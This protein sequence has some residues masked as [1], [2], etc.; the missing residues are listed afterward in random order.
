MQCPKCDYEP[1]LAEI[2]RSP[3]DCVS[4]GIN[5]DG[6]ARADAE[7][8]LREQGRAEA[9]EE[10]RISM[11]LK[12][13][14]AQP[15]VVVD[16]EMPFGSMVRLMVMWALAAIPAAIILAILFWGFLSIIKLL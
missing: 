3:S 7:E 4:C 10:S 13:R 1:S 15:V 14:T 11:A 5:Y 2:Q 16:V 9:R 6:Y 12:A 8:Q